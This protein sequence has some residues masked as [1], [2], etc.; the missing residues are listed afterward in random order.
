M[1]LCF[2]DLQYGSFW[3]EWIFG[4]NLIEDTPCIEQ[5]LP[6]V[7]DVPSPSREP[8]LHIQLSCDWIDDGMEDGRIKHDTDTV[9]VRVVLRYGEG[10][11]ENAFL[12][13]P[14]PDK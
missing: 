2:S 10:E 5:D 12:I 14:L 1:A 8:S 13:N 7:I 6:D 11:A 4:V 9:T 3:V